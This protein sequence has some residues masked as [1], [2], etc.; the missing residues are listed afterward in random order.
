MTDILGILVG[1]AFLVIMI[2]GG[3]LCRR[4]E[5]RDWNGGCCGCGLPWRSF[6]V[7]SQGCR[8]YKCDNPFHVPRVFWI[9][10]D[11]DRRPE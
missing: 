8:G 4:E 9:T 11:V 1:C 10:Y 3:A 2:V 6:D 7:S 5:I